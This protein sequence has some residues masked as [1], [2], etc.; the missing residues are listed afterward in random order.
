M[1]SGTRSG[2]GEPRGGYRRRPVH[3]RPAPAHA[4]P[5]QLQLDLAGLEHDGAAH[6]VL[7]RAHL[8]VHGLRREDAPAPPPREHG[9]G[10]GGRAAP[11]AAPGARGSG[12]AAPPG[13]RR[14]PL[15]RAPAG[16]TWHKRAHTRGARLTRL[17]QGSSGELCRP[18]RWPGRPSPGGGDLLPLLC[19]AERPART[20]PAPGQRVWR[21]PGRPR[22]PA[23][24]PPRLRLARAP[25]P[26]LCSPLVA[27][28][29]PRR[30]ERTTSPMVPRA[31]RR[32][33]GRRRA[34]WVGSARAGRALGPGGGDGGPGEG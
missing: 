34:R 19:L 3:R 2:A 30:P 8:R 6:G 31:G 12:T 23:R 20:P 17:A 21:G 4:H 28:R 10:L 18:R 24:P 26:G 1:R 7:H 29:A 11:T 33:P 14:R 16:E 5:L 9:R 27:P 22:H 32:A 13:Q 15:H 25:P